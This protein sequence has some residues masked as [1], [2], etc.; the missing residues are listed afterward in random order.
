M[1]SGRAAPG[2]VSMMLA[3]KSLALCLSLLVIPGSAA[4]AADPQHVVSPQQLAA[5]VNNHVANQDADR[6][7]VH[8]AL[9]RSDVQRVAAS[10]HVDLER[11]HAA[12]DTMSG[13]DLAR[14]ASAARQIAS[15]TASQNDDDLAGG[16]NTI[17]I[18]TTT[19]IIILL[20]LIL[21]VVLI[22][23]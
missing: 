21:L 16:S 4:A 13:P 11:A 9:R 23:A 18:S 17:V 12:V 19:I 6:A 2:G 10:I 20:L 15:E 7:A 14:A 22:K 5:T 3:R 8:D 1:P